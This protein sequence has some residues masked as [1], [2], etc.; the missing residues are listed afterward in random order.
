[1]LRERNLSDF[2]GVEVE[3]LGA[4]SLNGPRARPDAAREV[5]L[6]LTVSHPDKAALEI[7]AREIAPMGTGGAPGSTGFAGGRPKPQEIVRLFSF[8]L[9]KEDAPS[10]EILLDGAAPIRMPAPL[11]GA[12]AT[13]DQ[14]APR[15]EDAPL[16]GDEIEVPLHRLAL[17]RSGDKGDICN[18]GIIARSDALAGVLARE[19]SAERM[20]TWFAHLVDGQATRYAMP[21]IGAFNFVLAGAL[22]GGGMASLRNDAQGK[23]FAQ[24]ALEMPVRVSPSLIPP[25]VEVA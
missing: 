18:I 25:T 21:G 7:F 16:V 2:S 8:L 15:I 14:E 1:L 13:A 20:R 3:L 6:R 5:V 4:D 17:A 22:R 23:A 10:C 11:P 12:A 19:T 9:P 24:L